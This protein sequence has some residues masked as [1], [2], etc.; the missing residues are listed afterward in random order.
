MKRPPAKAAADSRIE[1]IRVDV[2]VD[3]ALKRTL[4]QERKLLGVLEAY[5]ETDLGPLSPGRVKS[6]PVKIG[7]Y[8]RKGQVVARMDDMQL[9]AT[10]AQF[11][12]VKAQYE[13]S[14]S[15]YESN[16]LPKAQ[17]EA[18]EAQYTAMK[19]QIASLQEN[20]VISAPFPGVVTATAVEEGE[21]YSAPMAAG[22]GQSKGLVHIMQ[23]DPLKLDLDIDAQSVER[24]KRGMKVRLTVDQVPESI[25]VMGTVE[26]VNPQASAAS[27]TFK[28]RLI[29]PN[30]SRTLRPGFFAEAH[31]ILDQKQDVISVPRSAVVDDRV[32]VISD[33]VAI[34]RKVTL[35]WITD[36]FAEIVSGLD[37]HAVVAVK[38]NKA[39]PDSALVNIEAPKQ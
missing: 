22:P 24:I 18:I 36:E 16:A 26:W 38:G 10:D 39:L 20:T 17:F 33:S 21:L 7:D 32:F 27:R 29:V 23:L 13:R 28:V 11:Q 35:G 15:L 1:R 6:L 4:F 12:Q 2:A 19:R 31:I 34:A 14:K 9:V 8:V 5:R 25:A 3:T 37:E 30:P